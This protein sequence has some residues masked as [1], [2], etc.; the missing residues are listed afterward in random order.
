MTLPPTSQAYKVDTAD[1]PA[2]WFAGGLVTFKAKADQ[3]N[4]LF[5]LSEWLCPRGW[6]GGPRHIHD[7]EEEA[8]YILDGE[9]SFVVGDSPFRACAGDFVY[10]PR[11]TPHTLTAESGAA[12]ALVL[13]TPAGLEEFFVQ[14][15]EPAQAAGFPTGEVRMPSPEE[16]IELGR[17]YGWR[18]ADPE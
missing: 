2:V 7:N 14:L 12:K 15:S 1:G 4:G 5:S 6:G 11:G 10:V 9:F 3:T 17:R 8:F 16:M 13:I 18:L